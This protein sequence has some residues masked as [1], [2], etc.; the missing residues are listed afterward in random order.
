MRWLDGITNLMDMSLGRL[1]EL[2]TDREAW[3]AVVHGAT[4]SWTRLSAW[5]ELKRIGLWDQFWPIH[6]DQVALG[7]EFTYQCRR[8]KR[9][10]FDPWVGKAPWSRKW[11]PTPVFLPGESHGER[12]LRD[13]SP[14]GHKES[15][16]TEK[17]SAASTIHWIEW[18]IP[19]GT[20]V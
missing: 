7:K 18:N 11:R 9:C 20:S 8:H 16:T 6:Y 19:L 10:E 12:S 1:R 15:N 14:W 2:V 5:P 13:Y 4:K 3:C 17:L